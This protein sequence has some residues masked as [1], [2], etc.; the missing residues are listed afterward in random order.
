[1]A[2][3]ST[4]KVFRTATKGLEFLHCR[5]TQP[6]TRRWHDDGQ[7]RKIGR[8]RRAARAGVAGSDRPWRIRPMV[9]GSDRGALCGRRG[10][11]RAND[12]PRLR[13]C[14]MGGMGGTDR[15]AAALL[16]S[17]ASV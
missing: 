2:A 10:L 5:G 17:L 6:A 7:Y 15:A 14:A 8:D 16:L 3:A 12:H 1:M 4:R 11:A 9:P 13:A